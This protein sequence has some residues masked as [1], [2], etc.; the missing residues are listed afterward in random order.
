VTELV[1]TLIL[2]LV[3]WWVGR[4]R[5][6]AHLAELDQK[7]RALAD[8]ALTN[9]RHAPSSWAIDSPQLVTGSVVISWDYFKAVVS[10]FH[11]LIGG[12]ITSLES[13]VDR[14]RRE[15]LVRLK[16]DARAAG[17]DGLIGLRLET[18]RLSN[19]SG[20]Q[21]LGGVEVLAYGTAVRR[22]GARTGAA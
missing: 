12:R 3:G 8:I 17:Y 7:E 6:Q 4:S 22:P 2:F 10:S 21:G 14:A 16:E 19:N 1:V 20:S 13:L 9:C 15:A 18:A 5:E 11:R